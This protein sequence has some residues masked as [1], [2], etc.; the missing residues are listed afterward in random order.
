[1]SEFIIP[2]NVREEKE[3]Y[4]EYDPSGLSLSSDLTAYLSDYVEDRKLGENVSI[5]I[6]SD[7]EP[8]M[9]RIRKSFILFID[10]LSRRNQREIRRNMI[11]SVRLI[12]IGIVFIVVG[13]VSANHINSVIAVIISTIGSFS[14]WEASAVWI[15]SLPA[16]R[17]KERLLNKFAEAKI[18][19]TGSGT[20]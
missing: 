10:K 16:L 8:D 9:E 13:I 2:I 18:R 12:V 15:E 7:T 11:N 1:M 3:L 4:T 14:V 20:K 6:R 17:K 5:E 19:Y